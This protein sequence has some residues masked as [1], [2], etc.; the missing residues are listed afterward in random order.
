M[1]RKKVF[2][3]GC[4]D[5]LH[6][7]HVAFFEEANTHGDVYVGLGSD[8]T[9]FSL[10]NRNTVN[11][12]E[13]RL[14]MVKS[15]K[16]VKD[17][18]V[19]KGSGIIDYLDEL[20]ALKPDILFV[21]EDGDAQSKKD[22]CEQLGIEYVVSKRIPKGDL[23]SRSTTSIR[24]KSI[25]PYRLDLAGGWLDQPYVSKHHPGPVITI[26]I[27]PTH[28]FNDRSGMSSSTRKKA[29]EIWGYSLPV[30]DPEK[31]AK[32][33][34]SFENP[35]GKKE[36]SGSQD[37]IGIVFPGLNI[38]HYNGEYWPYSIK[39]CFEEDILCWVEERLHFLPLNPRARGYDVLANT[40]INPENAKALADATDALWTAIMKK[41]TE[42]FGHYFRKSFEGQVAMFPN[43][44]NKEVSDMIDKY[45]NL[46]LGWKLAGAGG[47]GYLVLV[48]EQDI[49]G[50]IKIK[51]RRKQKID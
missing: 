31:L 5:L 46:A 49:P 4:Y 37:S 15:I 10:K 20:R 17:A 3:S 13:E 1:K 25:I 14:Y 30:D 6:S 48:S 44:K 28:D 11:T 43:M 36:I 19:N 51:I 9:I 2:V 26:S 50:T 24:S 33:L 34:F 23:P 40:K 21:N 45:Q 27:E 18:W 42:A 22:L 32:V 29:I 12:E 38:M 39:S 35:P 8:R 47:G 41:D 16:Y 7:G